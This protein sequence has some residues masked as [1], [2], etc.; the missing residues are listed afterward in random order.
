MPIVTGPLFSLQ[1]KKVMGK[2]LEF[3]TSKGNAVVSKKH[4][5][6]DR[7]PFTLHPK[8][9]NARVYMTEAVSSWQQLTNEQKQE[10]NDFVK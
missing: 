4:K 8:Q 2:V 10:W 7:G 5:P 3:R 6:G 9:L 1:A